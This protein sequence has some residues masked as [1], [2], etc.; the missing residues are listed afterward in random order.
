VSDNSPLAP[1][2][3]EAEEVRVDN[4]QPETGE[5][6]RILSLEGGGARPAMTHCRPSPEVT[7]R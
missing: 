1:A 7:A 5:V 3:K 2:F 4:P 6:R